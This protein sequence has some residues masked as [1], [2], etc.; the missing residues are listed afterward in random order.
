M[1]RALKEEYAKKRARAFAER[2]ARVTQL[3]RELPEL[4]RL[5]EARRAL[6]LDRGRA[7]LC[8][9]A[10][11]SIDEEIVKLD[12][13]R[14]T[15]LRQRGLDEAVFLPKFDCPL[16]GDTGFVGQT[17]KTPCAC[18]KR[19]EAE[20]RFSRANLHDEDRF[21]LFREDVYPDETQRK[22]T[23]KLRDICETY[24][25][26]FPAEGA[27]GLLI[28]GESGLGKTF[29][30][31]CIAQR[32]LERGYSA[33]DLTVYGLMRD[34]MA[35]IKSRESAE[36]YTLCDLLIIDD[37]GSEPAYG[38]ITVQTLFSILNER[39]NLKRPTLFATNLTPEQINQTYGE[40]LFSRIF[41]P[42]L[43]SVYQLTG[44]DLRTLR[45]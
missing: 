16:C 3:Y 37:L 4:Q 12:E 6:I 44:T 33:A 41:A 8:E 25:D 13:A 26:A 20:G 1:D 45:K 2:D 10:T 29:L 23:K 42:R 40:R 27:K 14:T 32:V 17:V 39:Q 21:E 22:R 43:T 34:V 38:G 11:S 18:L 9:R 5:C 19:R 24:A 35:R 31:R 36:D 15:L 28:Y 30:L 7:A